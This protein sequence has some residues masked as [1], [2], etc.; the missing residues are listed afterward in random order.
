MVASTPA[1]LTLDDLGG[2]RYGAPHPENDPEGR[3]VVFSGQL[4]AQMIIAADRSV[5]GAHDVKSIHAVFSRA[6]TYECPLE[7]RLDTTHAGRLFGSTTVTAFQNDRLL[8]RSM[9]LLNAYED[10]FVRH[11][12]AAPSVPGPESLDDDAASLAYP[13][14]ETRTVPDLDE[15]APDGTPSL[16]FWMRVPEGFASAA[17]NQAVLAWSQPGALIGVALRPHAEQASI[18]DAHGSISTGVIA[19]TAHFHERFDVGEWML[20]QQYAT[21]V[22]HGRVYGEGRVY[23][24]DGRLVSTFSQDSMVRQADR[25]LDSRRSM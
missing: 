15:T 1:V 8:S 20:V 14:A 4:L 2:G 3:N 21:F 12:P 18:S 22:G 5:D 24:H 13:G 11:G 19:H 17:V 9:L 6:G 23:D 25:P 16:T 7:L 10:D